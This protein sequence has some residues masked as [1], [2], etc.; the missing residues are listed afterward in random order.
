MPDHEKCKCGEAN[1]FLE[2]VLG[3]M[4]CGAQ[5]RCTNCGRT[6]PTAY[7]EV[8]VD[9]IAAWSAWD[10]D[11]REEGRLRE[12]ARSISLMPLGELVYR[13]TAESAVSIATAALK[14]ADDE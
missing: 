10:K 5:V 1:A 9:E 7:G 11:R 3:R 8:V 2:V 14:E 12:A 6:G 4:P 13:Q